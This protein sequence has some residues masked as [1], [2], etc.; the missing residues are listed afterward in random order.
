[1]IITGSL[2]SYITLRYIAKGKDTLNWVET[3][4]TIKWSEVKEIMVNNGTGMR[5][6]NM[7]SKS[8]SINYSYNFNNTKY[9]S[10]YY[11]AGSF[12]FNDNPSVSEYSKGD[13]LYE[14]VNNY[15]IDSEAICYVNPKN[16]GEAV[17]KRGCNWDNSNTNMYSVFTLITVILIIFGLFFI[18]AVH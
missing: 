7:G 13:N 9:S 8:V 11:Y 14:I 2:L 16:P 6:N 18:I 17:L 10:P 3:P 12:P 15:P 5:T 1:M 4:C